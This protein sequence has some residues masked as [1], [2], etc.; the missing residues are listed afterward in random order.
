MAK[1]VEQPKNS[2]ADAVS[3]AKEDKNTSTSEREKNED[4][5]ILLN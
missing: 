3:G 2:Y 5:L 1:I 4:K